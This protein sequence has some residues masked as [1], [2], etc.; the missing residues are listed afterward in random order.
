MNEQINKY[1][2]TKLKSYREKVISALR[3]KDKRPCEEQFLATFAALILKKRFGGS[4]SSH[5]RRKFFGNF[6]AIL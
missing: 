5:F 6:V 4:C 2:A 3:A 1:P